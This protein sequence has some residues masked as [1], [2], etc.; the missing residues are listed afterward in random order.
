MGPWRMG[1]S[2]FDIRLTRIYTDGGRA[3]WGAGGALNPQPASA[4]LN[5][6]SRSGA[7]GLATIRGVDGRVPR[8]GERR[9]RS[10]PEGSSRK[11]TSPGDVG[12][13]NRSQRPANSRG[14][15]IDKGCMANPGR[16][17]RRRAG[18]S[19]SGA[20]PPAPRSH[21][22]GRGGCCLALSRLEGICLVAGDRLRRHWAKRT[23]APSRAMTQPTSQI[24]SP[25]E[26][27]LICKARMAMK[28]RPGPNVQR[29]TVAQ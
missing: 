29:P 26:S 4:G 11:P 9:T 6:P 23:T 21:G 27:G 8:G 5:S 20:H 12:K 10:G 3:R 24:G 28:K 18:R 7:S 16:L 19:A 2:G 15:A 13:P 14:G 17:A 1:E 25:N 22:D